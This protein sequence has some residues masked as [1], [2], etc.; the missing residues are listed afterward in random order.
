[1][2]ILAQETIVPT[3]NNTN[4]CVVIIM[5]ATPKRKAPGGKGSKKKGK[6]SLLSGYMHPSFL[7]STSVE[8]SAEDDVG[9]KVVNDSNPLFRPFLSNLKFT[10]LA[11]L[12]YVSLYFMVPKAEAEAM[13]SRREAAEMKSMK[14]FTVAPIHGDLCRQYWER[15]V[16]LVEALFLEFVPGFNEEMLKG[17][18]GL[19]TL[20]IYGEAPIFSEITVLINDFQDERVGIV[21]DKATEED[22]GRLQDIFKLMAYFFRGYLLLVVSSYALYVRFSV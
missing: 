13:K 9:S 12:Y 14:P 7:N 15:K 2:L 21:K 18:L 3:S 8:F 17:G 1:M 16:K 5:A 11:D 6:K 19:N 4:C 10:E 20:F 22:V